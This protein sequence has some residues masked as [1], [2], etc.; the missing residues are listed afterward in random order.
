METIVNSPIFDSVNTNC[1]VKIFLPDH[2]SITDSIIDT[3]EKLGINRKQVNIIHTA[4]L[5]HDYYYSSS[6][7]ARLYELALDQ[8]PLTLAYVAVGK[9]DVDMAKRFLRDYPQSEF[10]KHWLAY[11]KLAMPG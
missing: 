3:Y 6:K 9:K 5:K 11:K 4:K 2:R 8:C 7:G 10:N 1:D